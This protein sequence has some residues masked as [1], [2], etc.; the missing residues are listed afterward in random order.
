KTGMFQ[1]N[2][3]GSDMDWIKKAMNEG[4][5]IT[6]APDAEA[7]YDMKTHSQLVKKQVRLG[8]YK[9][10]DKSSKEVSFLKHT[11][12]LLLQFRPPNPRF[13]QRVWTFNQLDIKSPFFFIQI[14]FGLWY[15]RSIK[16][17]AALGF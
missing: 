7:L 6:Y 5:R 9:R 4:V 15:Y 12:L 11:L 13:I 3:S 2:R 1:T 14:F 16:V 8:I 17:L 10:Y